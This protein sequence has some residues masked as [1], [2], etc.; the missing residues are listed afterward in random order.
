M[1]LP[2]PMNEP[3]PTPLEDRPHKRRP[4]PLAL[5]VAMRPKQ[6]MKNL[7]VLAGLLFTLDRRHPLNDFQLVGGGFL[8]FCLLSS[9]VYLIN[10]LVDQESDRRHPRKRRRPIACGELPP[11]VAIAAAV[12]FGAIGLGGAVALNPMF[13]AVAILYFLLTLGYSFHFK[14][15]VIIDVLVLAAGFVLRA[16]AGVV[17]IQAGLSNWLILCTLMLALFLGL[18]KRRAELIAME[19]SGATGTRRILNEYTSGMLDQMIVIVTSSCLMSYSLYTIESDAAARHHYLMVTIPFVIYGIFRYLYLMHRHMLGESPD[20]VILED[21]PT[22]INI[23]LWGVTTALIV[24]H[25]FDPLLS[26]LTH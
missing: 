25:V 9:V 1:G 18:S 14:H 4:V 10:D 15:I 17:L 24:S 2:D 19:R 13:G 11:K 8:L 23:A 20:A 12:I 3:L 16:I 22:L 5:L 21:R 26:H 7:L 6:W